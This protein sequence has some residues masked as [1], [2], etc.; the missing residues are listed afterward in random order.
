MSS[1][2]KHKYPLFILCYGIPYLVTFQA[3]YTLLL[4]IYTCNMTQNIHYLHVEMNRL[5]NV[6]IFFIH[7]CILLYITVICDDIYKYKKVLS[8]T[9]CV[10]INIDRTSTTYN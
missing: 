4:H 1:D 9:V 3:K 2:S 10:H 6:L 5:Y 7:K 8:Y